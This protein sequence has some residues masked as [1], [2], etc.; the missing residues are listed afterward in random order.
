M[1]S[2]CIAVGGGRRLRATEGMFQPNTSYVIPYRVAR[3]D[4]SMYTCWVLGM[5]N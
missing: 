4:L 1:S 2:E 3:S 5:D